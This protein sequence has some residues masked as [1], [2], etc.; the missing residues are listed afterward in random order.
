MWYICLVL[1]LCF[2]FLIPIA[3]LL[4]AKSS[5]LKKIKLSF[6]YS[7]YWA[8]GLSTFCMFIPINFSNCDGSFLSGIREFFSTVSKAMTVFGGGCDEKIINASLPFAPE[9]IRVV[10]QVLG[11]FL[12][13]LGPILAVGFVLSFFG[14]ISEKIKLRFSHFDNL[15]V[16]T[17]LTEKSLIL[18]NDFV[19]DEKTTI[20]FTG[21]LDTTKEE[22]ASL[23][24]RAK[25]LGAICLKQD[26]TD[27][28]FNKHSKKKNIAIFVM[29]ENETENL[30]VSLKLIEKYKT[31]ANTDLYVFSVKKDC[32]IILSADNKGEIKVRRINE[33]QSNVY[34]Y[35]YEFGEKLFETAKENDHGT[36]TISAVVVGMGKYGT[37]FIKALSW[38]C[39]MDGYELE[40]NGFDK[41]KLAKEKFTALA[42]DLM[43]PKYNNVYVEGEAQYNINIHSDFDVDTDS[44]Y[45]KI[46]EIKNATYVLVSLG[47]DDDN[48]RVSLELRALFERMNIHP[49]INTIVY[50]SDQKKNLESIKN[51]KGQEYDI[52]SI[53]ELTKTYSKAV[54]INSKLEKAGKAVHMKYDGSKEDDFWNYEYCYSSSIA[55]AIHKKARISCGIKGANKDEKDLTI[56]ERDIIEPLEHRRWNAY[57]RASGYVYNEKRYDLAKTH[58]DLIAFAKLSESEKR[59]D[60]IV[61]TE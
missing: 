56:E 10:Y 16:F 23:L 3:A 48:I 26:V 42:P 33:V 13:I 34:G 6:F 22:Y 60:S 44:F 31:R 38:Y 9:N 20:V 43:N 47:N 4:F 21:I 17:Q 52:K 61:A 53:G 58:N 28:N 12:S 59:K 39:Q 25:N 49:I 41:N 32:E 46:N 57:M 55:S 14:N 24:E 11:E 19:S 5:F 37:E 29:S 45:K 54:I 40:I 2:L 50:N 18:A 30:N 51:Y 1:S 36:K 27:I 7:L 8:V 35:L 15:R